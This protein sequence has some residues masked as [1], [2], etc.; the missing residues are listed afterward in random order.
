MASNQKCLVA[1]LSMAVVAMAVGCG[2]TTDPSGGLNSDVFNS[3]ANRAQSPAP[4]NSAAYPSANTT[5]TIRPANRSP[6]A[7]PVPNRPG[8][9]SVTQRPRAKAASPTVPQ[10]PKISGSIQPNSTAKPNSQVA[11]Q[12][13]NRTASPTDNG[14][15]SKR[16]TWQ[17]QTQTLASGVT[18]S[19]SV[20][21]NWVRYSTAIGEMSGYEWVNPANSKE[22]ISVMATGRL[23]SSQPSTSD[24][25]NLFSAN[26]AVEWTSVAANRQSGY[27]TSAGPL[28]PS[29]APLAPT[30]SGEPYRGYGFAEIVPTRPPTAFV[31]EAWAPASVAQTSVQSI[32]AQF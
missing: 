25:T 5:G 27:F 6:Q 2:Q 14:A 7:G 17:T 3:V 12:S 21:S 13:A 1:L 4:A 10:G 20:P 30:S 24:I 29:G 15:A 32:N 9:T 23:S 26:G 22:R 18:V 31:V 28:Y 19:L 11:G 8:N 16:L